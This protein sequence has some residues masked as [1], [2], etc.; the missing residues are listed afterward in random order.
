MIQRFLA[1]CVREP[2]ES[3]VAQRLYSALVVVNRIEE[4]QERENHE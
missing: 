4:H 3:P 2:C 1:K